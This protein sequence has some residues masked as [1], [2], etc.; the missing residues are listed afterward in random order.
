MKENLKK[1]IACLWI[2]GS[3]LS[4]CKSFTTEGNFYS[5]G[6]YA[7]RRNQYDIAVENLVQAVNIDREY[8][9]AILLLDQIYPEGIEYYRGILRRI[10]GRDDLEALDSRANSYISLVSMVRSIQDAPSLIHPKT[11]EPIRFPLYE[12]NAE[13]EAAVLAAAEGHYQ[14]G[15]RL[16]SQGSRESD[17][18]A[19]K[20]FL[21][22]LDYVP[23]YKDA[24]KREEEARSGASQQLLFLP[25]RGERS[26]RS[27]LDVNEYLLDYVISAVLKDDKALEY[28]TIV[29]RSLM[30]MALE[31]Q[32]LQLTGLFDESLSIEIG[33]MV[34]ANMVFN[35][36]ITQVNLEASEPQI[37]REKR[38][39]SVT[40]TAA[41][42][43]REP[44][45]GETVTV[46][47]ECSFHSLSSSARL[48]GG[49]KL[50]DIE[51][52]TVLLNETYRV[53][54]DDFARW[55]VL[56]GDNRVLS[57]EEKLLAMEQDRGVSSPD[58]LLL[59][60]ADELGRNVAQALI[61]YL[62]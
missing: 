12:Y 24:E 32:Q 10:E 50:I 51:T 29:D 17:K 41:E 62:R 54:R 52:G 57:E 42:L 34:S 13:K 11:A 27:N 16:A 40:P 19:S 23:S 45:E 31:E 61:A 22:T 47:G 28:T 43:G 25:F 36:T 58:D 26:Y 8:K 44:L 30:E 33:Q 1:G 4:G 21:R 20:E 3:L 14:E 37:I 48:V 55:L 35:G 46:S 53:E 59:E 56:E 49:F 6:K 38:D 15:I 39:R 5:Q 60:C 9:K 18:A 7:A 2:V